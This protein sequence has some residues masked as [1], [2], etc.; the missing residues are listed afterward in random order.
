[1]YD[2]IIIGAGLAGL[3]AALKERNRGS[4]LVL[5]AEKRAGGRI[6]TIRKPWQHESGAGRIH[7]SHKRVLEL[8][9]HYGIETSK[10]I[11]IEPA[12]VSLDK[13]DQIQANTFMQDIR[14]IIKEIRLM[15][16]DAARKTTIATVAA[17]KFPTLWQQLRYKYPYSGELFVAN[18]WE[19]ACAIENTMT[20]RDGWVFPKA[21][22]EALID[23][24]MAD[25]SGAVHL[26]E[27]VVS[28]SSDGKK[29]I[30][31]TSRATYETA[32]VLITSRSAAATLVVPPA[33][34]TALIEGTVT[35][36]MIRVYAKWPTCWFEGIPTFTTDAKLRYF[37]AGSDNHAMISYTD[38]TDTEPFLR[39]TEQEVVRTVLGELRRLFP[40]RHIPEPEFIA[41]YSWKAAASFWLPCTNPPEL[42]R[43]AT[44]LGKKGLFIAGE[45][46]T[47]HM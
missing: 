10:S 3:Y 12:Y 24:M 41:I 4:I 44:A 47:A 25:L 22:N 35:K 17:A 13:P 1:M 42:R 38:A 8:F 30:I 26:G 5:E 34:I 36:P 2:L 7:L 29:W 33:P 23:C 37:I 32:A 39:M 46:C 40:S 9:D 14:P 6:H 20:I 31:S 18:A 43:S 45:W 27:S 11:T 16:A 15:G 28:V 19:G 21:G